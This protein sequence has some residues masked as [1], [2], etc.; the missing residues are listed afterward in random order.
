MRCRAQRR[1]RPGGIVQSGVLVQLGTLVHFVPR[2]TPTIGAKTAAR[3]RREPPGDRRRALVLVTA[4]SGQGALSERTGRRWR[5]SAVAAAVLAHRL[6]RTL[7]D[8][9]AAVR[10]ASASAGQSKNHLQCSPIT[11]DRPA[12]APRVN[13]SAK[14][15][16]PA[17]RPS[18]A[19]IFCGEPRRSVD[20]RGGRRDGN[21]APLNNGSM[22]RRLA[23]PTFVGTQG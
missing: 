8:G 12:S 14:L 2:P 13:A 15:R 9:S 23:D 1:I 5:W 6:P 10:A 20:F 19:A 18:A 3:V 4:P 11:V 7:T 17:R 21:P 16:P 22:V